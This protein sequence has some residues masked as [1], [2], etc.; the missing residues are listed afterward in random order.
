[1]E[2]Q[3]LDDSINQR[4][5]ILRE[6]ESTEAQFRKD[7]YHAQSE[8]H[9]LSRGASDQLENARVH[10]TFLVSLEKQL[11]SEI[12]EC[13]TGDK[14]STV[15]DEATPGRPTVAH[16]HHQYH[17]V[18]PNPNEESQ[19][20]RRSESNSDTVFTYGE[21]LKNKETR[22]AD[23]LE[24][25]KNEK[26]EL[27]D[28]REQAGT[29]KA[30][31]SQLEQVIRDQGLEDA[32]KKAQEEASRRQVELEKDRGVYQAAQADLNMIQDECGAGAKELVELVRCDDVYPCWTI[33]LLCG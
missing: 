18:T 19:N 17:S 4:K 10:D 5:A 31:H 33:C 28:I 11:N 3:S 1:M 22:V 24:T 23:L 9:S 14:C 25:L 15:G 32:L 12:V 30:K 13:I 6:E 8:M 20:R 2:I 27:Q 21:L 26:K 7:L 16:D 29:L